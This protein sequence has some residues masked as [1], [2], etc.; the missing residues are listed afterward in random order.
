MRVQIVQNAQGRLVK[1]GCR[2]RHGSAQEGD[3]K[4]DVWSRMRGTV[5]QG[6]YNGLEVTEIFRLWFLLAGERSGDKAREVAVGW[7]IGGA[8]STLS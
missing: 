7:R 1:L 4:R 5:K 6:T 3:G 8:E 2:P